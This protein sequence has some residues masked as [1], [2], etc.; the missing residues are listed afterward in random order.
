MNYLAESMNDLDIKKIQTGDEEASR[1]F[2]DAVY[3]MI[4]RKV[5]YTIKNRNE[6]EDLTQDI[7]LKIFT[8]LSKFQVDK[9]V[10]AFWRWCMAIAK[11]AVYDYLRQQKLKGTDLLEDIYESGYENEIDQFLSPESDVVEKETIHLLQEAMQKLGE[12]ERE[13]LLLYG[14]EGLTH[15]EIAESLGITVS[16]SRKGY[17]RAIRQLRAIVEQIEPEVSTS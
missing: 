11:N 13:I 16:A 17:H 12:R 5:Y 14:F 6:A 9:G 2:F 15:K 3:P 4:W 10:V 7:F 1:K 8:N